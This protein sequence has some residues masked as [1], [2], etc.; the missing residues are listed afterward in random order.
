MNSRIFLI[1]A[2]VSVLVLSVLFLLTDSEIRYVILQESGIKLK[3]QMISDSYKMEMIAGGIPAPYHIGLLGNDVF[4]NERF[5]GNLYVIKNGYFEDQPILNVSI[6]NEQ[7]EIVGL[8]SNDSSIFIHV[9]E[10]DYE[11]D[12]YRNN[13]VL[14]YSWNGESLSFVQEI[15]PEILFTDPHHSGG[16]VM[17]EKRNIFS[18][19]PYIVEYHLFDY[20]AW[21]VHG[22]D[23]DSTKNTIWHT[24]E[25]DE[26]E[27]GVIVG[28]DGK[29]HSVSM[30]NTD[31]H[32]AWIVPYYPNSL[33]IPEISSSKEYQNSL[34]VGFCNGEEIKGGIL[35]Y[36]L[37]SQRTDFSIQNIE[38]DFR[39][40]DHLKYLITGN[41]YCVSD[42]EPGPDGSLYVTDYTKTGAIYKI[43]PNS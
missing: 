25:I 13:R 20:F 4:F 12:E 28:R 19:F 22:I 27:D 42:I 1:I 5:S 43:V 32:K 37:N 24:S 36:P 29:I 10:I 2:F 14:E 31:N 26:I 33:H 11:K 3:P 38:N 40:I 9:T 6:D 17:D 34:Y 16:I 30:E 21:G 8:A 39:E 23:Y 18:T 41:F 35:E 15:I 7:T